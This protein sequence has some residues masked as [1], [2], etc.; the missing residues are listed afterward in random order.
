MGEVEWSGGAG[1]S[2]VASQGRGG[3]HV[4][5]LLELTWGRAGSGEP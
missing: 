2:G 1:Q 4:P 3:R 5:R